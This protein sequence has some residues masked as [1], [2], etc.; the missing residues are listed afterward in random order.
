MIRL[1]PAG[2]Q[3][4]GLVFGESDAGHGMGKPVHKLIDALEKHGIRS[5]R[6]PIEAWNG[7]HDPDGFVIG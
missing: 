7:G 5:L 1:G 4:H 6:R 3:S 2:L